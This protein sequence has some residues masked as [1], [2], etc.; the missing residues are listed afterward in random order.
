MNQLNFLQFEQ[1]TDSIFLL[2]NFTF[3]TVKVLISFLVL[4]ADYLASSIYLL[5]LRKN[6][7]KV[8]FFLYVRTL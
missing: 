4:P 1:D 5:S 7:E 8:C 6:S 2:W 3:E